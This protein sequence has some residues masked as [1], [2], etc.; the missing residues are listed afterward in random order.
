[1][2]QFAIFFIGTEEAAA[3]HRGFERT[4]DFHHLIVIEDV[5]VHALAG[6]L[7]RQLFDVVVRIAVLVIKAVADGEHQF[8][9]HRRLTVLA[10]PGDAILQD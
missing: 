2:Y 7:Q 1:M 10:Q 5:R 9:E 3:P 4:G 8:G 6:A